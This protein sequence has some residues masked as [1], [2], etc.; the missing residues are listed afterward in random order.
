MKTETEVIEQHEALYGTH[1][2]QVEEL[3]EEQEQPVKYITSATLKYAVNFNALY[4]VQKHPVKIHADNT[5]HGGL[6][7]YAP[8]KVK[9]A[10]NTGL[11][12][13]PDLTGKQLNIQECKLCH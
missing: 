13:C 3:V 9:L 2:G 6:S 8:R 5:C 4:M 11:V 7:D 1:E 10:N 12:V